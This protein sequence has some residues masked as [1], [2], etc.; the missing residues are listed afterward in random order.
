MANR[1]AVCVNGSPNWRAFMNVSEPGESTPK[2]DTSLKAH[3]VS[4]VLAELLHVYR[5]KTADIAGSVGDL[6]DTCKEMEEIYLK[7]DEQ[8]ISDNILVKNVMN[9]L[10]NYSQNILKKI[11]TK[12]L[13]V[14]KSRYC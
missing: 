7:I 2:S 5:H 10:K 11:L 6:V 8:L 13:G 1:P 12:N 14:I 3:S 9:I 4:V